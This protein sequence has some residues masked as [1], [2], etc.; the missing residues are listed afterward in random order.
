MRRMTKGQIELALEIAR[1]KT[2]IIELSTDDNYGIAHLNAEG[3]I[4]DPNNI[5]Q[6][7]LMI[8]GNKL[9][10]EFHK[11]PDDYYTI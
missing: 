4:N 2:M 1:G 6:T 5:I 3:I 9:I 8:H 11:P 7:I 10:T